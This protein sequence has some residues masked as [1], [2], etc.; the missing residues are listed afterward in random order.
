MNASVQMIVGLGNPG[1]E[2]ANTRH[3]AGQDFVEDLARA[4]G[5]VM[6][7]TPKHFGL[8]GRI[9]LGGKDVRLLI[10]TTFMNR[11]GQAVASLANFFKI[12][13]ENILV[14]HDELDLSPGIAKLKI[15]GGHGGHNGLRDI[16]SSLGN[17]KNFGRLRVGIGHPGNANQVTGYVLKKAPLAEQN[18]IEDAIRKSESSIPDLVAGDWEKAMRELHTN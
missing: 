6:S 11:S 3:N 13:P 14:V 17:N 9:T 7:N 10:P 16:I 12:A 4:N 8:T 5:Q 1:A 2:Y 18:M 15:G